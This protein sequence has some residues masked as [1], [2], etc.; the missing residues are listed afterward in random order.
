MKY[1]M[2]A[3]KQ[4]KYKFESITCRPKT[5][6]M[7][8]IILSLIFFISISPSFS[9][10]KHIKLLVL[11]TEK[12][13]VKYFDSLNNLKSNPYY[14][15]TRDV[16]ED[17][18]LILRAEYSLDDEQFY[19][20]T[21]ISTIFQRAENGV[22]VCIRQIIKGSTK[23]ASSNLSFIKDNFKW[24]SEGKWEKLPYANSPLKF[25]ANFGKQNDLYMIIYDAVEV[26]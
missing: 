24:I 9:Q 20:C 14:K 25:V 11:K 8:K 21:N 17:G 6:F 1:L 15:I 4:K 5:N 12:E 19:T 3:L 16:S 13:V 7:K 10:I 23:F 18:D 22:E 26:N 2:S